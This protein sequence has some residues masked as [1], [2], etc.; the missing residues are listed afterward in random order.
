MQPYHCHNGTYLESIKTEQATSEEV[1]LLLKKIQNHEASS[2]LTSREGLLLNKNRIFIPKPSFLVD[3]IISTIHNSC[4][5]GYQKTLHRITRDF[6]WT[7]MRR[8]VVNYVSSCLTC[9]K[10]KVKQLQPAGL[11]QPLPVPHHIWSDISMDFVEGLPSSHGRNVIFVVVDR[12]SMYAHFLALSHPYTAVSVAKLF[13]DNIFKLHG[14]PETIVGDRDVTFT[15]SFWKELFRLQGTQLCFSSSYHPQPDGQTEAVNRVLEMYLRCFTSDYP[16]KWVEWLAWAE[17]CY[18]TSF[19][20]SLKTSPFEVV[21]GRS[22]PKL[23]S[24][25]HGLSKIEAVDHA[26]HSRDAM[27]QSVRGRLLHAQNIMKSRYDLHHRELVLEVG[28][29]VLL[30]LQPYRQISLSARRNKKLSSRYYGPFK[31]L[32]RVGKVAYK[33]ELPDAAKMHPVFHV[34]FLKRFRGNPDESLHC[35]QY[36]LMTS[37]RFHR[38]SSTRKS[39]RVG[40]SY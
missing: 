20:S 23:T 14:L 8:D 30:K 36:S 26:L 22:P 28:D 6:F 17:F 18:N 10:H 21:Y 12:F 35:H 32:Q 5:E 2:P 37:C 4:H 27:I 34:S 9:Q 7:G 25:C 16:K 31:V 19:H 29:W 24:Y 33:L 1:Q 13:F 39:Q 38:R 11:L 15:S 3:R 40:A